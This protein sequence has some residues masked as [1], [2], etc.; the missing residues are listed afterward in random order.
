MVAVPRISPRTVPRVIPSAPIGCTIVTSVPECI[1]I[2]R[3]P[4]S[5]VVPRISIP[6][7][8]VGRAVHPP[9]VAVRSPG[10]S[11]ICGGISHERVDIDCGHVRVLKVQRERFRRLCG[12]DLSRA[13]PRVEKLLFG[14]GGQRVRLFP[15]LCGFR[16]CR[17][18]RTR[19]IYPVILTCARLHC[20]P[21]G[22][23]HHGA[24]RGR[25]ESRQSCSVKFNFH[26]C[27]SLLLF[28]ATRAQNKL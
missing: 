7:G 10:I 27:I 21:T 11:P 14:E 25:N 1:V 18:F 12:L 17:L 26:L 19:V 23:K 5:S 2:P 4:I 9:A 28:F 24:Y 8:V 15:V 13:V 16:R 3:I 22:G 6:S 20:R